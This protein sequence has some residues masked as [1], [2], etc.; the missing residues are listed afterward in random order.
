VES[1]YHLV[2]TADE[3][4]W[5]GSGKI[6]FLG[7]WCLQYRRKQYWSHLNY[8]V[9]KPYGMDKSKKDLD[10]TRVLNAEEKIFPALVDILNEFHG[11]NHTHRYWKILL[12][13]WLRRAVDTLLNRWATLKVCIDTYPIASVS[14]YGEEKV[15]VEPYDTAEAIWWFNENCWN[16]EITKRI[17]D[18][19][20]PSIHQITVDPSENRRP[21]GEIRD[22]VVKMRNSFIGFSKNAAVN[23][24]RLLSHGLMRETDAFIIGSYLPK[25]ESI[26]L[27][28]ALAQF[29]QIW[30]LPRP[31]RLARPN[32]KLRD[33]FAN[34]LS[35]IGG[36][37]F[38]KILQ[39]ILFCIFPVCYLEGFN[40][41]RN[42]VDR[43]R[44]PKKPKFIY[45][46]NSF[47]TDEV[48]KVWTAQMVN[49]GYRYIVGQH[50]N[51]YGTMGRNLNPTNE[52]VT[53]DRFLTW[54]WKDGLQQHVSAFIFKLAGIPEERH[55]VGEKLLLIEA[56]PNHRCTTWDCIEEFETYFEDQKRFINNL[57]SVQKQKLIVRLHS[58]FQKKA[59]AEDL[60]WVEFDESIRVDRGVAPSNNLIK[61][62]KLVV[63]SYDSTG[64]LETLRLNIP[65]VAFWQSGF[66]H[67][68]ESAR[69]FYQELVNVGIVHFSP[70]SAAIHVT[71]VWSDVNKWWHSESV[72]LARLRFCDRYARTVLMPIADL[73]SCLLSQ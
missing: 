10:Y 6:L 20:A 27:Q 73:K 34:R 48:F 54:G 58:E 1:S 13:H 60:R 67:L 35:K 69:P 38:E 4:T 61:E 12:G 40:F 26:K 11:T 29:P 70:E 7:K 19:I 30:H 57:G 5:I 2:A 42:Q 41:L 66:D 9:A 24:Y 56:C 33:D 65:T 36:D 71:Q 53:C 17:L 49:N 3:N 31:E 43:L 63:H 22:C 21:D 62:S 14:V 51:N 64:I 46:C 45:T 32:L 72:Q 16:V 55:R 44:F 50:G 39:R 47:D 37:E 18:I 68:R 23:V 8:T 25:S 15:L 28:I 52:E 59:G